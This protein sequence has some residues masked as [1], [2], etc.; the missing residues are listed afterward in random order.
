MVDRFFDRMWLQQLLRLRTVSNRS[1]F[2]CVFVAVLERSWVTRF[3]AALRPVRMVGET[4][5]PS[6]PV[7]A[8]R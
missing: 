6:K 5:S 7:T 4:I 3:E 8:R 1:V 2:V